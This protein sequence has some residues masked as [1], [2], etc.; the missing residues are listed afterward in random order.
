[1]TAPQPTPDSRVL[2]V[3]R[4]MCEDSI[5]D[6]VEWHGRCVRAVEAITAR[7]LVLDP[8]D[9]ATRTRAIAAVE[10]LECQ[11]PDP[12]VAEY[13]DAVLKALRGSR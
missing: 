9:E 12:S 10:L 13:V 3:H 11:S 1:M 7:W 4:E 5:V 2:A 8:D 6:C